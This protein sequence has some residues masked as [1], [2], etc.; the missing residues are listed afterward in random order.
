VSQR[1]GARLIALA[2]GNGLGQVAPFLCSKGPHF[3]SVLQEGWK[4]ANIL[5]SSGV[6]WRIPASPRP[7]PGLYAFSIERLGLRIGTTPE[8]GPQSQNNGGK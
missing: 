7:T 4:D 5:A 8:H 1:C 3:A 6:I 2:E